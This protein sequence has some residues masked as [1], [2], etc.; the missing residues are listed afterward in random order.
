MKNDLMQRVNFRELGGYKSSNGKKVRSH[1]LFRS[2]EM[3]ELTSEDVAYLESIGLSFICD[4]RSEE[5]Q[6]EKPNPRITGVSNLSN[7]AMGGAVAMQD[8]SDFF[9]SL[10]V[11]GASAQDPLLEAYRQFV[12]DPKSRQA[13]RQLIGSILEAEG[14][15]ILWHCTAG[16]DRT[17]FAAAILLL[18][19]DVPMETIMED[20]LMTAL[21]RQEA[22]AKIIDQLRHVVQNEEHLSLIR[23]LLGVKPEYLQ[24]SVTEMQRVYGSIENYLTEGLGISQTDREQLQAWYL[25]EI[26]DEA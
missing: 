18:I 25:T 19:L 21:Y 3:S 5:E 26:E 23:S 14:E 20:Y 4:L 9:K 11:N 1:R 15:P 16:K 10:G 13:Y 6:R 12:S 2:G 7:P 17:G 8:L 22:N 24:A